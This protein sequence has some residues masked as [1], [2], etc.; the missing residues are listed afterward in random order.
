MI[1]R[2]GAL[3]DLERSRCTVKRRADLFT[4]R[5][6]LRSPLTACLTRASSVLK[7]ALAGLVRSSVK[8]SSGNVAVKT[9][10]GPGGEVVPA[11]VVCAG[12]AAAVVAGVAA[13]VLGV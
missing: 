3:T 9:Y 12:V 11:V 8:G 10:V 5:F 13:A 7:A 1:N 6:T 2:G 4:L